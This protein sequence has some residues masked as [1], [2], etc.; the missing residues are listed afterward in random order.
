MEEQV[1]KYKKRFRHYLQDKDVKKVKGT[2]QKSI[3]KL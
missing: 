3:T 2:Q 1:C